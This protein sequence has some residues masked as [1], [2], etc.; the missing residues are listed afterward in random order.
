MALVI[1]LGSV[2]GFVLGY[3]LAECID[4]FFKRMLLRRINKK[5]YMEYISSL[6]YLLSK[7]Y[8][9]RYESLCC[10]CRDFLEVKD[11]KIYCRKP[12]ACKGCFLND[13]KFKSSN[14]PIYTN[15]EFFKFRGYVTEE[16]KRAYEEAEAARLA[17]HRIM[18]SG[19]PVRYF[20][21]CQK[22]KENE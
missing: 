5:R 14:Y 19:E 6:L 21:D 9:I 17:Y 12:L 22:G 18:V 4:A 13:E 15:S 20:F 2:I 16:Y 1:V 7:Q 3:F 8:G 10:D 11:K